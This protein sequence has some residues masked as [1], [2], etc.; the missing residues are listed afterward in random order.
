MKQPILLVD[1][2]YG[3]YSFQCLIEKIDETLKKQIPQ[4]IIEDLLSGPENENYWEAAA[5]L[6]CIELEYEN[7]NWHITSNEDLWLVPESFMQSEEYESWI[8]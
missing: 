8:I 5:D 3:I 7:E 6:E 1:S 2:H 4:D